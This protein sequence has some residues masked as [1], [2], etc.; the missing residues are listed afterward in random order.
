MSLKGFHVFFI[1]LATLLAAGCAAWAL[2]TQAMPA[3]G[4]GCAVVAVVLAV[5]GVFF[6]RKSKSIIT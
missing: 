4:I 3:F 2:V 5:Y 1:V 6:V